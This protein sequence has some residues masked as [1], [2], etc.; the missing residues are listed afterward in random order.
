MDSVNCIYLNNK[1][2]DIAKCKGVGCDIKLNCYRFT[3]EPNFYRQSYFVESPIKDGKCDLFWG[4][5]SKSI[6]D[7]LLDITKQQDK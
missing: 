5:Q 6:M 2:L 1:T 4:E 3:S 7:Q